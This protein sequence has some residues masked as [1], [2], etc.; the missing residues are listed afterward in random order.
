MP[1]ATRDD[2][3]ESATRARWHMPNWFDVLWSNSKARVGLVLLLMFFLVAILAPL[4]AP[5]DP[6]DTNFMPAMQPDGEHLLGTTQ[7]GQDVLSQLIWGAR[8]SLIVAVLGGGLATVISL[9]IGMTAGYMQGIVDDTLSFFINLAMVIP[10]LPLM[11][12]LAAYAPVRG[13]SLTIFV[14][15]ITGW[16]W[17]ARMKRSQVITLRAREYITSARFAGEK[18][19]RIIFRE[20]MPNMM[21]FVVM[22][23]IGAA[24]GAIGA[25]AGLAFLGLGDPATISWGSM[26]YWANT[27]SAMLTGQYAWLIAPGLM[28]SLITLALTLVN[29]GVDA[30]S[31]PRLREE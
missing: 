17:G 6:H 15:G 14:I 1:E 2:N 21:S 28:L 19:G 8:T 3:A 16:A 11:I 22:S 20:V 5:Y 12:S 4:L 27:N 23:F 18:S 25:E 31:N 30:L 9:I 13:L 7:A 24:N 26:L 29:F 10:T